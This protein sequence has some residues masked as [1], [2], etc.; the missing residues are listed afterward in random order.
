[1]TSAWITMEGRCHFDITPIQTDEDGVEDPGGFSRGFAEHDIS[2]KKETATRDAIE[3][4][5]PLAAHVMRMP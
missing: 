5:Q 4:K 3:T 1:M 2:S